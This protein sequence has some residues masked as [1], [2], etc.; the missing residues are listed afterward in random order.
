[1]AEITVKEY[2]EEEVPKV[3]EEQMAKTQV[4]GMEGT[5]FTLQF[6]IV[7]DETQSYGLTIKDAKEMEVTA[8]PLE[9]A[10]IKVVLAEDVWRNAVTGQ[11]E[12]AMDMFT[13][14]GQVASRQSYDT[15]QNTKGTV[16]IVLTMPDGSVTETKMVLNGADTPQVTLKAALEDWV[17]MQS[18][19]LPGP[20]AFMSGKLKLE[21]DMPFAMSLGNLM[22]G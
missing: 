8:G 7:G 15:L 6:D 5:V 9:D 11:T 13:D 21:G 14:M 16:D 2:F 19:E 12:G 10:M 3:F 4:A 22:G 1:M 18:G 17:K 20:T